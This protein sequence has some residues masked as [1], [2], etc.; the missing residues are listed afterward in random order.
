MAV[1]EFRR[2]RIAQGIRRKIDSYHYE[3]SQGN[4]VEFCESCKRFRLAKTVHSYEDCSL[5]NECTTSL[6]K[7]GKS[8]KR[9]KT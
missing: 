4:E 6:A 3:D 9:T 1:D 7:C 8:R 5:C 2:L